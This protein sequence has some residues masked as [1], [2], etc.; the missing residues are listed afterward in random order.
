MPKEKKIKARRREAEEAI[1]S[2]V[3]WA[4]GAGL[5]PVPLFDLVAVTAIQMDLLKNLTRIY[6]VDYSAGQGKAFVS[7]LTGSTFAKIGSSAVKALPGVGAVLGGVSMSALSGAS[8]YATG[9]VALQHL[10]RDGVDFLEIDLDR[11]KAAYDDALE[12]GKEFV[13]GLKGREDEPPDVFEKLGKLGELKK[14]GV[15]SKE[16]FAAKKR[17]LL[18]RI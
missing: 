4:V 8:T 5:M 1:R 15:I 2:H 17:E 10:G 16:E 3:V 9:V 12:R 6:D 14:K 13:E 7:A 11:A 18:K